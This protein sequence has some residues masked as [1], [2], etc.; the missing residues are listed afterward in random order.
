M[1]DIVRN[2]AQVR[3]RQ[4][5]ADG[6]PARRHKNVLGG[7]GFAVCQFDGMRTL[8][9]GALIE[10]FN[11][12]VCQKLAID[13]FKA[14]QFAVHPVLEKMPVKGTVLNVPA[15]KFGFIDRF[16]IARSKDHQLLRHATA[17]D[18]GSAISIVFGQAYLGPVFTR[19]DTCRAYAT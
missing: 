11:I 16:G 3:I 10:H 7:A 12:R 1:K 19:R 9:P 8:D 15:K 13:P 4:I 5:R 14:V 6:P 18:A 17:D 2:D